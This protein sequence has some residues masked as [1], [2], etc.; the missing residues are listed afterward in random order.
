MPIKGTPLGEREAISFDAIV[1]TIATARLVLPATTIRL[2]AGRNTMPEEKQMLCFMAGANA[3]FTGERMLTTACNGW[4]EDKEM[5][6]R[7]GLRPMESHKIVQGQQ[8]Q[9]QNAAAQFLEDSITC[10]PSKS[11]SFGL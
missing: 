2:A 10:S 7:W 11:T 1:R 3:V 4:E 6:E 8:D 9:S 5:F